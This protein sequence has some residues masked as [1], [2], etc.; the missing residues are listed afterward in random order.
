MTSASS[1]SLSSSS[2]SDSIMGAA[3]LLV[4]CLRATAFGLRFETIE[5]KPRDDYRL[6][7][8]SPLGGRCRFALG[9]RCLAPGARMGG[10]RNRP[11]PTTSP[12]RRCGSS[13]SLL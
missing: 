5:Q 1:S 10:G 2:S 12:A 9:G 4:G 7:L 8:Q 3:L 6:L 11:A 13:S